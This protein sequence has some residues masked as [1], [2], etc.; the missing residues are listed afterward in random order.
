MLYLRECRAP[1][2]AAAMAK[3]KAASA[4]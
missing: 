2:Y 4:F 3:V 1:T